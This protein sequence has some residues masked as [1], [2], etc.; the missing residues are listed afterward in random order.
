MKNYSWLDSILDTFLE[1]RQSYN[2]VLREEI[3][4]MK[5]LELNSLKGSEWWKEE[6]INQKDIVFDEIELCAFK[7][8]ALIKYVCLL[9]DRKDFSHLKQI[10]EHTDLKCRNLDEHEKKTLEVIFIETL[11]TYA[12]NNKVQEKVLSLLGPCLKN[13]YNENNDFWMS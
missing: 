2:D 1:V 4:H 11:M 9:I 6:D 10:L 7:R 13:L 12:E 5:S 8:E 3:Q